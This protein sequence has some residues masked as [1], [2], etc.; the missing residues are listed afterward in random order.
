[1]QQFASLAIV[2]VSAVI[3]VAAYLQALHFPF[4]SDDLNSL[5]RMP[6]CQGCS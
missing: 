5:L 3:A 6:S 4:V 1:M 2:L